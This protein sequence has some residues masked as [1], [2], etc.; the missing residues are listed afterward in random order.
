MVINL[1]HYINERKTLNILIFIEY[2]VVNNYHIASLYSP[3]FFQ[4]TD[5]FQFQV[6]LYDIILIILYK[7]DVKVFFLKQI[8][9]EEIKISCISFL[10]KFITPQT[11]LIKTEVV[12][13]WT[14]C[15]QPQK[16][17]CLMKHCL[18]PKHENALN[19]SEKIMRTRVDILTVAILSC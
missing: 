3:F 7:Q 5:L 6:I 17:L 18:K 1:Q 9:K 15:M 16:I 8:Q 10:F 14:T 2:S 12:L 4:I 13:F 19:G 11:M